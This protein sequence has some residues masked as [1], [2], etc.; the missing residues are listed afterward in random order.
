[1]TRA[2]SGVRA[3]C[4]RPEPEQAACAVCAGQIIPHLAD[5]TKR[6]GL[7]LAGSTWEDG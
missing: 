2:L 6:S 7:D 5:L 3:R 1:M 4:S